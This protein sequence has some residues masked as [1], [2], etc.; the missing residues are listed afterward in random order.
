[1]PEPPPPPGTPAPRRGCPAR[2]PGRDHHAVPPEAR[3]AAGSSPTRDPS[4]VPVPS[5][6]PR[7]CFTRSRLGAATAIRHDA[8]MAAGERLGFWQR[9]AI[10]IVK[11]VLTV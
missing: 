9:F 10:A 5:T 7:D 3:P 1:P 4:P 6:P 11:P 2:A 8:L